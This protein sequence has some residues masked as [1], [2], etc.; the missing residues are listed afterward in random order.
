M[1]AFAVV[2][3]FVVFT[4]LSFAGGSDLTGT[5]VDSNDKPIEDATI[6]IYTA[7]VKV[8]T[9][10]FCP[11]CYADCGR[12]TNTDK[13]GK[14]LLPSLDSTLLFKVLVVAEGYLPD[15]LIKTDP[16]AG[17]VKT[18]LKELPDERLGVENM[19]KGRVVGP[20]GKPVVG[21]TIE[22]EYS[23]EDTDPFAVTNR[24]GEFVMTSKMRNRR[25]DVKVLARGL[26]PKKFSNVYAGETDH[27][28]K[29][30][31]GSSVTGR[32]MN[33]GKP[34]ANAVMGIVSVSRSGQF[35]NEVTIGTDRQGFFNFE[36]RPANQDYYV[37]AKRETVKH[38]GASPVVRIKAGQD[39]GSADAGTLPLEPGLT[40]SGRVILEDGSPIPEKTQLMLSRDDMWDAFFF[41]LGSDG[42]FSLKH[43]LPGK[44][45]VIIRIPGY[46]LSEKNGSVD[47]VRNRNLTGVFQE[48]TEDFVILFEKG[49]PKRG[50]NSRIP[51]ETW[52]LQ[53]KKS[54]EPLRGITSNSVR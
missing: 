9:S 49:E 14:F 28:L 25:F 3:I 45:D 38:L 13:K 7:G 10:P 52:D 50:L 34:V 1:R 53:R 12:K 51:K 22:L 15:F 46:H 18:V 30:N 33:E 20:F 26:A 6:L 42:V 11:S 27:T 8:G 16:S 40:I 54:A 44:Y 19:L 24:K 23:A 47:P 21:A 37:Y 35:V 31:F 39:D 41:V 5:I 2:T 17:P 32:L 4:P 43:I 29:L 48:D 36:N